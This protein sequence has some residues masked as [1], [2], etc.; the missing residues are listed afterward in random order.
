MKIAIELTETA[1]KESLTAVL[2]VYDNEGTVPDLLNQA[3][4]FRPD[5]KVVEVC[6]ADAGTL[7]RQMAVRLGNRQDCT[8]KNREEAGA[9]L[10]K[11]ASDSTD[12][13]LLLDLRQIGEDGLDLAAGMLLASWKFDLY[14]REEKPAK[15][16]RVVLL[17]SSVSA[18]E[19]KFHRIKAACEGVC[20]ARALTS[21][22]ANVF[23]PKAYGESL[24]ELKA[25]GVDV[26]LLDETALKSLG[27]TGILAVGKGSVHPPCIAI[28]T[29]NGAKTAKQPIAVV[30]KGVCFDSGGLCIK[31]TVHQYEMKW[32]K[33]GAGVVAGVIKS[34]A[35]AKAPVH[36]IGILGLVENMPDGAATKPGDVIKTMSG[37][38]VEILNT[39]AEGRLVLADCLWYAQKRYAPSAI[40]DLGT[41]TM[42]TFASLGNYYAGMYVNDRTLAKELK[43][44][45]EISGD[46]VWE[47]PMG[48]PF[49]KQIE[50]E[51][52]DFK[53]LGVELCGEN[54]AAAEF[55]RRF[56]AD[57][58]W[59]HLDIAGVSWSKEDLPLSVKGVTGFGVRLLEEWILKRG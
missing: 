28:L 5:A 20:Y 25:I 41:M 24:N 57:V 46:E 45:G 16:K 58:P 12:A 27:M 32:D 14:R 43:E 11:K 29:W 18:L 50:S 49:A 34:L 38:T 19:K 9:E 17:C 53:N 52:A 6:Y 59:A 15:L 44:A 51:V 56:V 37:Q 33:A 3:L 21:Q 13:A 36:V 35:L 55:L 10:Y 8:R 30:G 22:P 39:D 40:V 47:L 42:E 1:P 7:K 23:F 31:P 54:G 26:E 2:P 4:H 48:A